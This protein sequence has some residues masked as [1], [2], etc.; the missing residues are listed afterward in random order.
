MSASV[1][2]FSDVEG[3]AYLGGCSYEDEEDFCQPDGYFPGMKED[4]IADLK[5]KLIALKK[6]LNNI[7]LEES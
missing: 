3:V 2:C 1:E 7:N 6:S 5:N 4:A